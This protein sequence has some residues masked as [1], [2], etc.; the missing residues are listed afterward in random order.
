MEFPINDILRLHMSLNDAKT[1]LLKS[2][3]TKHLNVL[4]FGMILIFALSV[5]AMH[6]D[7]DVHV[8][9][10]PKE[11]GFNLNLVSNKN[12]AQAVV[13]CGLGNSIIPVRFNNRPEVVLVELEAG[14]TGQYFL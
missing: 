4:L 10:G 5:W 14:G 7:Y 11:S 3:L 9:F 6:E 2:L 1:R 8:S 12:D 13:S